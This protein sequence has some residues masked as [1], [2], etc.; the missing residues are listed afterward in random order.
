MVMNSYKYIFVFLFV[1]ISFNSY[2]QKSVVLSALAKYNVDTSVLNPNLGANSMNYPYDLKRVVTT[3]QSE[4]IYLSSFNPQKTGSERWTLLSVNGKQPSGTDLKNFNK[5][6]ETVFNY[7]INE[8]TLKVARDDGKILQITYR[9]DPASIDADHSFLKD[10]LFT[11]V[12]NATTG[13]LQS[14]LQKNLKDLKIKIVKA[15]KLD[16][17]SDYMYNEKDKKYLPANC[18]IVVV[19]KLIGQ[20][21]SIITTDTYSYKL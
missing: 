10:C 21:V 17:H 18:E 3:E 19:M 4:K 12:I 7:K 20:Q 14:V 16:G 13:K 8:N 2:S 6:H 15:S 5:E 11:M 9:Y 1:F